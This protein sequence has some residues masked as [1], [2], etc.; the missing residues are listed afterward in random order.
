VAPD[1]RPRKC[2]CLYFEHGPPVFCGKHAAQQQRDEERGLRRAVRDQAEAH[3]HDL[4]DFSEYESQKGKWTA[5][6]RRCFALMIVYDEVPARGDQ[7]N[8]KKV[9][10]ERCSP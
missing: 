4:T 3:G 1:I 10:E 7:V 2:G 8:G 5:H 9:L 6:C